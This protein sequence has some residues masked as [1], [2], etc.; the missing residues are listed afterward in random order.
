MS[1]SRREAVSTACSLGVVL[2]PAAVG[3]EGVAPEL[4][5]TLGPPPVTRG[6]LAAWCGIAERI[7]AWRDQHPDTSLPDHHAPG[8]DEFADLRLRLRLHLA[9]RRHGMA[10]LAK[11]APAIIDHASQFDDGPPTPALEDRTA[12]QPT[13]DA[14]DRALTVEQAARSM[15]RGL[16]IEL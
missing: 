11:R 5:R 9:D 14:A 1:S 10:A 13:V 4:W 6:G 12:W 2:G 3:E 15:D 7:E 16:G 8:A